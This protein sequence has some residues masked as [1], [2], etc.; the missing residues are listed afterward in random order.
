MVGAAAGEARRDE[1]QDGEAV[2]S[3]PPGEGER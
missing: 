1:A 2:M 3:M